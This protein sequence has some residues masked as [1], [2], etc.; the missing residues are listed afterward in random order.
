MA[1][2]ARGPIW[3]S[4]SRSSV[5]WTTSLYMAQI[6]VYFEYSILQGR[7]RDAS[8]GSHGLMGVNPASP[9]QEVLE[10]TKFPNEGPGWDNNNAPHQGHMIDLRYL[11]IQ[12]TRDAVPQTR[13]VAKAFEVQQGKEEGLTKFL[14]RLRAQIRRYNGID[15]INPVGQCM[16]KLHFVTNSWPHISKKLKK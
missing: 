5:P 16:F 15:S 1:D 13:I 7:K 12:G 4:R 9:A 8:K 3:G 2:I 10:E 11:I 14:E 6:N